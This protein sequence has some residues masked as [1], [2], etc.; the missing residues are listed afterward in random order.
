MASLYLSNRNL[1]DLELLLNGG[2]APLKG[3]MNQSDY[4]SVLEKMRLADGSLWPMP[5]V[6]SIDEKQYQQFKSEDSI[7]LLSE[8]STPL[9]TLWVE[10]FYQPD[11]SYECRQVC[12]TQDTNHPYVNSAL[13]QPSGIYYVGGRVEKVKEIPYYDFEEYRLTPQETKQYFGQNNWKTIVGFQT[14]NP[15]HRCH[16]ELTRYALREATKMT[17][18]QAKLLLHPVVGE[19]QPGDIDYFTRVKC[20]QRLLDRYPEKTVKLVLLP[21]AM[22]MAGPREALWHALIRKNYGCTHFVIGRDHAGPSA[23]TEQGE[24]FYHPYEAQQLVTKYQDEIGIEVIFSKQ[25]V[26]VEKRKSYHPVD[27]LPSDSKWLTLSGTKLREMIR[28]KSDIPEWFTFPEVAELLKLDN[29]R[30]SRQGLC[31][32][33]V[34]LSGSGK[35]TLSNGMKSRLLGCCG[36]SILDRRITILDGD[37]IRQH[38]SKG[39]TFSQEDRSTNIRRIGYVASE[40]VKH[41]GICLCANIAPF[42]ADRDF[43]RSIIAQFGYYVEVFVDTPLELCEK[44]DVKGLYK[45]ARNGSIPNFTG[46]SDPFERPE[47]AEIRIISEE[48]TSIKQNLDVIIDYLERNVFPLS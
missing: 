3:F 32:Y 23:K 6:L 20:Y 39:L 31:L 2:F 26:Y 46:V 1:Y 24:S 47:Q 33:F 25:I 38:L 36:A 44:R 15:M 16:Y 5:I 13:S 27:Q 41:G 19:T 10:D 40:I 4:L 7:A 37:V 48:N 30:Q 42:Q 8:Q 28:N 34:G 43:N 12:G 45:L 29:I 14:R 22:R 18:Q 21:L 35:S 11:L 17:G 9:A